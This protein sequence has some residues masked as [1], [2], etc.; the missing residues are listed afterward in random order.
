MDPRLAAR[1]W[2]LRDLRRVEWRR[3]LLAVALLAA[4]ARILAPL[5]AQAG[6]GPGPGDPVFCI[7]ADALPVADGGAS[8]PSHAERVCPLCR[9]TDVPA[10]L[11]P[12][13]PSLRL[14]TPHAA[15]VPTILPAVSPLSV[16]LPHPPA[17]GPPVI[18]TTR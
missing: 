9:L 15:L 6:P 10:G 17:R 18:A 3:L 14:P 11:V 7:T 16:P 13:A 1:A 12:P 8:T 4:W 2:L 5:P